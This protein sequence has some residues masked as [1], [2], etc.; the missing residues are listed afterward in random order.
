MD[1]Y[2]FISVSV[3]E[4]FREHMII[5][6]LQECIQSGWTSADSLCTKS[7]DLGIRQ[8]H[9]QSLILSKVYQLMHVVASLVSIFV[10]VDRH[11]TY[12]LNNYRNRQPLTETTALSQA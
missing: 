5:V 1:T 8:Y 10:F 7:K 4:N 6:C 12:V 3:Q 2:I 11:A 9:I